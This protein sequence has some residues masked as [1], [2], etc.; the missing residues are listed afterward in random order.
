MESGNYRLSGSSRTLR[1]AHI[2][3]LHY[4]YHVGCAQRISVAHFSA[5]HIQEVPPKEL[6]S[7]AVCT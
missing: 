6:C 1:V 2:Y 4:K 3:D 7:G 5:N